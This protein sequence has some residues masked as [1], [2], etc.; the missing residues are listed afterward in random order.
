MSL[1]PDAIVLPSGENA[2]ARIPDEW[3]ESVRCIKPVSKSQSLIVMSTDADAIVL[4]FGE[5]DT[6]EIELEWP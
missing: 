2:T 3:P 1:D 6:A 4:E 5:N